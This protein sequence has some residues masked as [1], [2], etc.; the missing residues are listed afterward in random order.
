MAEERVRRSERLVAVVKVLVDRPGAVLSLSDLARRFGAAKS[1]ISE[2]LAIIRE[3]LARFGLGRVE[4]LPGAAGGVRY[5]PERPRAEALATVEAFCRQVASPDRILAGGFLYLSDLIFSPT[6]ASAFGEIFADRFRPL[7]PDYV[8]TVETKGI[9]MALMTARALDRPLVIS[10]R[11]VRVT[12]GTAV[13]INYVSASSRRI[14]SM[15]LP[16]RALPAG[17]RVVFVD[18]FMKGG[19]TARGMMDLVAEF[20]ARLLAIGVL[21]ETADPPRKMVEDYV[22]LAV[23]E[24]VDEIARVIRVR[25]SAWLGQGR[26]GRA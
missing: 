22:S 25:P 5:L 24:A 18:D 3:S 6:W 16:R 4:T 1:T 8:L 19:G 14:Q 12:E 21:L 9:P 17:A 11:D 23:L 20:D 10:R 15:S 2:D 26:E 13:H 7:A